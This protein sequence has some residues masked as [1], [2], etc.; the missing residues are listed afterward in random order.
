MTPAHVMCLCTRISEDAWLLTE[1]AMLATK[2]DEFV[3][4]MKEE[5]QAL[6]DAPFGEEML[7]SV[8]WVS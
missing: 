6:A 2:R 7:K 3:E 1:T 8:S 5:A 4:A